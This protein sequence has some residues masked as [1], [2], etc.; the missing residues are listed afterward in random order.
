M[1]TTTPDAGP[2]TV[3][4][5][6][7]DQ[8]GNID[9]MFEVLKRHEH[10]FILVG[11]ASSRWMGSRGCFD[12]AFDIVVRNHQLTDIVHDLIQT[13][14]WVA[15]DTQAARQEME[16]TDSHHHQ[17]YL[18]HCFEADAVLDRVDQHDNAFARLRLW[19]EHSY[20]IG[21]DECPLVEVP[22]LYAWNPFL[23]EE[24]YHPASN[25][26]DGWWY[27]P[28]TLTNRGER[29][30]ILPNL[31]RG[32]SADNTTPIFIPSIPAFLDALVDQIRLY[33]E[34]CK[35]ALAFYAGWQLDNLTRYLYLELPHQKNRILF[36][37][38]VRNDGYLEQH[39]RNYKR[40]P[41]YVIDMES[42][43]PVLANVWDP[44]SYP[45]SSRRRREGK[46]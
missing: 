15:F 10:P 32:K 36:E 37:V 38:E 1:R 6:N 19:S 12:K 46:A 43:Q 2:R 26:N 16:S 34:G 42:R 14:H 8:A 35:P 13:G 7:I 11:T 39:F 23:V 28:D 22:N 40:K 33:K 18:N 25:R 21:V 27:G 30:L 20:H 44:D 3:Y 4:G 9:H 5:D 41:F 45:A 31:P 24:I 29:E 17:R